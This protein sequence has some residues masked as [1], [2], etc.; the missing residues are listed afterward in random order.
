MSRKRTI[1]KVVEVAAA[2]A[3]SGVSTDGSL[4]R[5]AEK[6]LADT[7]AHV[8]GI[9]EAG[10]GPLAGPVVAAAAWVREG[11]QLPNIRDSKATTEAHREESFE[12]IM[13]LPPSDLVYGVSVIDHKEIDEINILQATMKAM[14]CACAELLSKTANTSKVTGTSKNKKAAKAGT[15]GGTCPDLVESNTVALIDGNRCPAE[16]PVSSKYVIKGDSFVYSI[17]V[18]S[19]IA[20]VTRDRIMLEM[21]R[22]YPQFN[23]AQHKGYPT[24][25]HRTALVRFGPCP[26]HRLTY[27]P[28]ARCLPAAAAAA[29]TATNKESAASD[30]VAAKTP[31]KGRGKTKHG[32][33]AAV[34]PE[35]KCSPRT[36]G[37]AV[38]PKKGKAAPAAA[39]AA[40]V[41]AVTPKSK[42]KKSPTKSA[43]KGAPTPTRASKRLK[44]K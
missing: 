15:L 12:L 19:I 4:T 11:V 18:A 13:K 29:A 35:V 6:K 33:F 31:A 21:D 3:P 10:R 9:D 30:E 22:L 36:R 17:S 16:M 23:F 27:G 7:F 39:A 26:I 14:R 2:A 20:K 38:T 37:A 32:A 40:A 1:E 24:L 41:S 5:A 34:V 42:A 8:I 43:E 28:V 44:L 25:A